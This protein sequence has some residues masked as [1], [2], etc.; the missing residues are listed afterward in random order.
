[1]I[2]LEAMN[3]YVAESKKWGAET[4]S[5][6]LERATSCKELARATTLEG[7]YIRVLGKKDAQERQ[8]GLC[9][10]AQKYAAVPPSMVHATL[11]QEVA[12]A[13]NKN[14]VR[15]CRSEVSSIESQSTRSRSSWVLH[16]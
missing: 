12:K 11:Q 9:K 6:F 16:V 1:M 4:G 10:Y 8:D 14:E 13:I 15:F 7:Q 5:A 2:I 3:V